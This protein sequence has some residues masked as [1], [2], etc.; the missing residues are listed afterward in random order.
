MIQES[1]T[2]KDIN[3]KLFWGG[4]LLQPLQGRQWPIRLTIV[5][6]RQLPV[7]PTTKADSDLSRIPSH[8]PRYIQLQVNQKTTL[9]SSR[10]VW[11]E[12]VRKWNRVPTGT[13][14]RVPFRKWARTLC[15]SG[16]IYPRS[17]CSESTYVTTLRTYFLHLLITRCFI[18]PS[19]KIL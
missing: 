11:T 18:Q 1:C 19:N 16:S 6:D 8:V 4:G 15:E 14:L 7:V 9:T 17:W 10:K 12:I 13:P 2:V 5:E 3:D